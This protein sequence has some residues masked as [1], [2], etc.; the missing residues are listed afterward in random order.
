MSPK[1]VAR[2][3]AGGVFGIWLAA[4]LAVADKP[5]PLGFVLVIALLLMCAVLVY[6]RAIV[7]LSWHD[8]SR[9]GRALRALSE[10]FAA[11]LAAALFFALFSRGEPSVAITMSG[12]LIWFVL[13]GSLGAATAVL[14]YACCSWLIRSGVFRER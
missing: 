14:V 13:L 1:R 3:C 12:L 9:R 7:Y 11:G 6:Y 5:P 2:R 8:D 4:A 10:G